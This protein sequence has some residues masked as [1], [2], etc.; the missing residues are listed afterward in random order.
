MTTVHGAGCSAMGARCQGTAGVR[1]GY[2]RSAPKAGIYFRGRSCREF[3]ARIGDSAKLSGARAGETAR[4]GCAYNSQ[5]AV[6]E[7]FLFGTAGRPRMGRCLSGPG[8]ARWSC[9]AL[10]VV[11]LVILAGPG[12]GLL[13]AQQEK[14]ASPLEDVPESQS[15]QP[16]QASPFEDVPEEI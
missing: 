9:C 15:P 13:P 6:R 2:S 12:A 10:L 8:R 7:A 11:C 4:L 1:V 3:S 14:P 16:R 5:L